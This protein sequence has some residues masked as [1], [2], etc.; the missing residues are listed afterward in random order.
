MNLLSSKKGAIA[1]GREEDAK[2][3]DTPVVK[4]IKGYDDLLEAKRSTA[5]SVKIAIGLCVFFGLVMIGVIVSVHI[6]TID[7]VKVVDRNGSVIPS[8]LGKQENLLQSFVETHC[9][10]TVYYLN[11]FDRITIKENQSRALFLVN[12]DDANRIFNQFTAQNNYADALTRGVVYTTKFDKLLGIDISKEPYR[13]RFQS[14]MT[15]ADNDQP[16]VRFLVIS[17]GEITNFSAQYPENQ[18]GLYFKK[19]MQEFKKLEE[20]GQKR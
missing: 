10:N 11:T 5:N 18:V 7:A 16:P 3:L 4:T 6:S 20:D 1:K 13:V 19:Y 8:E 12:A 2:L 9:A 14:I 15:V 17:E